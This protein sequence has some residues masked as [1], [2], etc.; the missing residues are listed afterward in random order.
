M[1]PTLAYFDADIERRLTSAVH[2]ELAALKTLQPVQRLRHASPGGRPLLAALGGPDLLQQWRRL[3][4]KRGSLVGDLIVV[5]LSD[6]QQVDMLVTLLESRTEAGGAVRV[7]ATP[8]PDMLH[9]LL[10]GQALGIA[11]QT[12][13]DA[14]LVGERLYITDAELN[15]HA[16]DVSRIRPLREMSEATRSEFTIHRSGRYLSWADGDVEMTLDGL[17]QASDDAYRVQSLVHD[18][19]RGVAWGRALRAVRETHGVSQSDIAGLSSRHL[20][21]I[22]S[23]QVQPTSASMQ[24]L[25]DRVGLS[26]N[27]LLKQVAIEARAGD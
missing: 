7:L 27:E 19:Q 17:R 22:E 8:R 10:R 11:R 23:G 15:R 20:R 9:R 5:Y 6:L 1:T 21:R 14:R 18:V 3:V 24:A 26:V 16:L 4:E 2:E 13:V 12:I 25:A